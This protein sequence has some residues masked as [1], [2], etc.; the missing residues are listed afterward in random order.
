M[1]P[2]SQGR[3]APPAY[4]AVAKDSYRR[5]CAAP[6]FF[7]CFYRNFFLACPEAKPLFARTDFER[8]HKLLQHAIG[9]LLVFP[10]QTTADQSLLNRVADRHSRRDL[11]IAPGMYPPFVDSLVQTAREHDPEFTEST[12]R[13][14]RQTVAPGVAYM[15]SRR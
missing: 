12:E 4:V 1:C 11:G 5:C 2:P 15:L 7:A 10:L 3:D 13:A 14:W 9:L 8:Q 6:D